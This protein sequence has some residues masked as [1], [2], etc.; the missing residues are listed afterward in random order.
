LKRELPL[1][2]EGDVLDSQ[3]AEGFD[4]AKTSIFKE[5]RLNIVR[6]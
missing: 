5:A 3:M 6:W 1:P 2:Y 4:I